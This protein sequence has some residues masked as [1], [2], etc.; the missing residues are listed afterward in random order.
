MKVDVYFLEELSVSEAWNAIAYRKRVRLF[1]K[2]AN[3][4]LSRRRRSITSIAVVVFAE[5]IRREVPDQKCT[6]LL[7]RTQR[8]LSRPPF[9]TSLPGPTTNQV[10]NVHIHLPEDGA[11]WFTCLKSR[12]HTGLPK[13]TAA[14][15]LVFP[16]RFSRTLNILT[17]LSNLLDSGC[18]SLWP[19]R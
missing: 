1:L 3:Q 13:S 18:W 2:Q 8:A 12:V 4:E 7:T 10:W 19:H 6:R 14:A 15:A 5:V 9:G 11:F 16:K 17:K